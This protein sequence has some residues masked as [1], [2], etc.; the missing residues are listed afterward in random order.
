[1]LDGIIIELRL[2]Y[3]SLSEYEFSSQI[4]MYQSFLK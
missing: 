4:W 1:M 3:S 2:L